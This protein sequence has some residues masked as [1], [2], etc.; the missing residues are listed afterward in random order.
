M[1]RILITIS[2]EFYG[3][4]IVTRFSTLLTLS[5]LSEYLIN[6]ATEYN[7]YMRSTYVEAT[8]LLNIISA[9]FVGR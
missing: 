5:K 6:R 1:S 8:V 7:I 9:S 4:K 3:T 2:L